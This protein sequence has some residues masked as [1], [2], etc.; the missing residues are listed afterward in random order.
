MHAERTIRRRLLLS[1]LSSDSID[2]HVIRDPLNV[3]HLTESGTWPDISA[4]TDEHLLLSASYSSPPTA[5]LAVSL[6]KGRRDWVPTFRIVDPMDD[7][8]APSTPVVQQ[9]RAGS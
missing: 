8:G 6:P 3:S 4:I 2:V 7:L 5:C 9:F 1:L